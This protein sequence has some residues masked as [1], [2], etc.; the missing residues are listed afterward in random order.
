VAARASVQLEDL[1]GKMHTLEVSD[2][3]TILDVALDAGVDLPYDCKMGVC[4]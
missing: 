3:E 2:G 1:E 4:L